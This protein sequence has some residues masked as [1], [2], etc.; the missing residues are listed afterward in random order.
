MRIDGTEGT[1][2]GLFHASGEKIMVY[3]HF[4]GSEREAYKRKL[5]LKSMTHGGGDELLIAAF[6]EAV[7]KRK[8]EPLTN[9]RAALE[10]HL[11]AFAAEKSR[12]EKNV[13]EMDEFRKD[14]ENL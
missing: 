6:L 11:M 1:I 12:A 10:S 5:S 2:I 9:A 4:S 3:D 13:I 14:V 8:E 7:Q